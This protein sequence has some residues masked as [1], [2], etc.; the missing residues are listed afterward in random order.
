MKRMIDEYNLVNSEAISEHCR[1]IKHKFN[2]EEL[3]VLIYRNK[4]M[5]I[6]E[7]ISAY[8][9]LIKNYPDMEV[10]ERINCNHYDSVKAM[11]KEEIKR[12]KQLKEKL[13]QEEQDVIYTYNYWCNSVGHIIT[14]GK[15]E[16]RDVYKT[17]QEIQKEID[18][19]LKEDEEQ[20]IISFLIRKREFSKDSTYNIVA[21]YKLNEDRKLEMVNIQDMKNDWLDI[22]GICLNIPT[23][24]QK[25]DLL[26]ATSQTPFAG[27]YVLNYEKFPFVLDHLITWNDKFQD[28]LRKGN[29]DCSD[30]QGP[31]YIINDNHEIL[32]D[33]VFDYDSWEY[34][35]GNLN[36]IERLL[37]A[38]SSLLKDE[39]DIT[40]F[41]SA[42]EKIMQEY[43][44]SFDWFTD[45]G[46]K[47]CG[48]SEKEILEIRGK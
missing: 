11:I 18:N 24:F 34:F 22:Q 26:M 4:R 37:K 31:G 46:L 16:Y 30:M 14:T 47:L 44:S 2:T 25:G 48:F 35:E 32:Y 27:G 6:D 5:N 38:V 13:E 39:I 43:H 40:L 20:E 15:D 33:N 42:Y 28:R 21:E 19:E 23:P 41:I 1:K 7:K 12:I 29:F 3:A 17:F 45:E 8:E 10:I 9:E 36:G